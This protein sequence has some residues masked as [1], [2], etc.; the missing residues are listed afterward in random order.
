MEYIFTSKRLGFRNWRES[1]KALYAEM[2][3][4]PDV[5]RFFPTI[6]TSKVSY[7]AVDRFSKHFYEN[8]YTYFAVDH[9]EDQKFIGFIGMMKQNF[10]SPYSPFVDIGWRLSKQYWGK[11]LAT[12][13]AKACMEFAKNDLNLLEIYSVATWNNVPSMNVMK[14]IGMYKIDEFIHPSFDKY[15]ELQPVFIFK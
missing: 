2:N 11:G 9:L 10:E 12:E 14:K 1:D 7:E 13:G 5:M 15:H 8:G 3:Q 4:D 6:P